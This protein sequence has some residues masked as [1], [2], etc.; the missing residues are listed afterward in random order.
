MTFPAM[1]QTL[2]NTLKFEFFQS[3]NVTHNTNL[4]NSTRQFF[5]ITR[6]LLALVQVQ[7]VTAPVKSTGENREENSFS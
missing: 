1:Y 2:A 4:K 5:A 7:G 3:F 6:N